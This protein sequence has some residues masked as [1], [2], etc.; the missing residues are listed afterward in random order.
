MML[1]IFKIK[2]LYYFCLKIQCLG[3]NKRK[4]VIFFGGHMSVKRFG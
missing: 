3:S 4:V 1:R 2:Y